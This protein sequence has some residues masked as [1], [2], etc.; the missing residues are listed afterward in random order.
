MRI[1]AI[2]DSLTAGT[3]YFQSPVESSPDGRGNPEGQYVYWMAKKHPDWQITNQGVAGQRSDQVAERLKGVLSS[4]TSYRY[5]IIQAGVNDIYQNYPLSH[6]K[7][8]LHWMYQFARSQGHI[9]VAVSVLPFNRATPQQ[10]KSIQELNQWIQERAQKDK[11]LFCDLYSTAVDSKDPF[12]L[13]GSID[14]FHPDIPT[15]RLTGENLAGLI[16]DVE[17]GKIQLKM[18]FWE[19]VGSVIPGIRW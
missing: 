6:T 7:R 13:K 9:V 15:Y 14:G 8:Y 12:R 5:V 3:P 11:N 4:R 1:L 10:S 19:Y 18:N 2:G 17:A 16:A